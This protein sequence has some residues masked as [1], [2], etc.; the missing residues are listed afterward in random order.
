MK[1][2]AILCTIALACVSSASAQLSGLGGTLIVT[3]KSPSTATIIDV[4][5]GRTLATLPTGAGPHEVVVSPSGM[6]A[7]VTDYAGTPGNPGKTL[8]VLLLPQQRV[9]KT[10]DLGQYTRPHG[11]VFLP[12]DSLVAVTSETTG[13]VVIV[14]ILRGTMRAIAT[15]G[16]GSHMVGVSAD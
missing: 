16:Q 14:D 12:G 4:G 2:L 7:V 10:I 1:R 9:E 8:T 11:I 3:N 5:S 6:R 15:M 13:N